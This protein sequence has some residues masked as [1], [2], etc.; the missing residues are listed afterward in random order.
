[1]RW[2][3]LCSGIGGFDLGLL[4]AGHTIDAYAEF[5]KPAIACYSRHFPA[6]GGHNL[7]D[8][9]AIHPDDLPASDAWCAGFPCQPFSMAGRRLGTKD[10][11]GSLAFKILRLAGQRRPRYLLFENVPGLLSSAC[12]A[13]FAAL[14][15]ALHE[16]G[17]D[18]EWQ[19]LNGANWLPQSRTR[20]FIVGRARDQRAPQLLPVAPGRGKPA[21][22]RPAAPCGI[23]GGE[24]PRRLH[25]VVNSL[26]GPYRVRAT[27]GTACTL[28]TASGGGTAT[29]LYAVALDN[30]TS[31]GTPVRPDAAPTI[32]TG[33]SGGGV[34]VPYPKK[35]PRA[36][37][38]LQ[39]RDSR[40]VREGT[41]PSL[42]TNANVGVTGPD[43]GR[44]PDGR[45]IRRLTP[46]ECE[47]L[48]GFPDN[49]TAGI[50]NY[51]RYTLLG[52]SVMPPVAEYLGRLFNDALA[53]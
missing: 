21:R 46:L 1:M 6:S 10:D 19:C 42:G 53:A 30:R 38:L 3:S 12:G 28:K 45:A 39:R 23:G 17:Y 4:R 26:Y 11:R 49:W 37:E 25:T 41:A 29:G 14:L 43:I 16:I 7:G 33:K 8:I 44:L 47:R 31:H 5:Y 15:N 51:I 20:L 27:D 52:N 40:A 13:D 48:Q 9:T 36:V 18:A 50:P 32:R 22:P 34:A 2:V 35:P 24:A